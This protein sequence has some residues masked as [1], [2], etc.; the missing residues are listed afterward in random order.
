M[1]EQ[2]RELIR[3]SGIRNCE[4][5]ESS[6]MELPF[7]DGSFDAVLSW[8]FLHHVQDVPG[9]IAEIRRVLAPRGRY[10]AL[11]PNIL[12]PSILWYHLRRKSEWRIFMQNQLSVP[13]ALRRAGFDVTVRYDNTIISFLNEK[14]R[15]L[16]Q[17]VDRFTSVAPL[18]LLSFR[19]VLDARL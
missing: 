1:L 2:A 16:W 4:V 18:H 11:E 6:A 12:N 15:S 8:D 14:T 7:P 3:R 10:V 19:Y 13:R 17:A 5:L 9:T